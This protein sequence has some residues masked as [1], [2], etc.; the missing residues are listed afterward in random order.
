MPALES[1][2]VT[3]SDCVMMQL[4][5]T[6]DLA[7][8][9]SGYITADVDEKELNGIPLFEKENVVMFGYIR[10]R[11]EEHSEWGKRFLEFMMANLESGDPVKDQME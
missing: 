2:V 5:Q 11:Q 9:G 8:I 1:V 10:R 4:L 6:T 7:N 3:N